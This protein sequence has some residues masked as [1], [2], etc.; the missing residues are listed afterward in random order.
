MATREGLLGE[1]V[2]EYY[3]MSLAMI[4]GSFFAGSTPLGGGSTAYP[5][6]VLLLDFTPIEGRDFAAMIQ[7]VGMGSATYLILLRRRHLLR[8][9]ILLINCFVGTMALA[10]A[11][12]VEIDSFALNCAFTTNL[13]CFSVIFFYFSEFLPWYT[14]KYHSKKNELD[15]EFTDHTGMSSVEKELADRFQEFD[16]YNEVAV[17]QHHD[18][19]RS[20]GVEPTSSVVHVDEV[21]LHV[22]IAASSEVGD[23]D[24]DLAQLAEENE[25]F[26]T[27]GSSVGSRSADSVAGEAPDEERVLQFALDAGGGAASTAPQTTST[28]RVVSFA[29]GTSSGSLDA[30]A[31]S[32]QESQ[33][34]DNASTSLSKSTGGRSRSSRNRLRRRARERVSERLV[35]EGV[36]SLDLDRSEQK[37]KTLEAEDAAARERERKE[38][39][40]ERKQLL[41]LATSSAGAASANSAKDP[42]KVGRKNSGAVETSKAGSGGA[43]ASCATTSAEGAGATRRGEDDIGQTAVATGSATDLGDEETRTSGMVEIVQE[44]LPSP[45]NRPADQTRAQVEMGDKSAPE[46]K[47]LLMMLFAI[48]GGILS[49]HIGGGAMVVGVFMA[50]VFVWNPLSSESEQLDITTITLNSVVSQAV[51]SWLVSF[52]ILASGGPTLRVWRCWASTVPIVVFGAPTGAILL[53]PKRIKYFR[54]LFI[55]LTVVQ[56]VCFA[57]LKIQS[58]LTA[59]ASILGTIGCIVVGLSLYHQTV[60]RPLLQVTGK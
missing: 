19:Q 41:G 28:R 38:R 58:D 30:G 21:G 47:Y 4:P 20:K 33:A 23:N 34:V 35:K 42:A 9:D 46:I 15:S 29:R 48:F 24:N 45:T 37:L 59:W 1:T 17:D 55:F 2:P 52:L 57:S 25:N 16:E 14:V 27:G 60:V 51:S 8:Q 12:N 11:F 18:E 13:L 26:S 10:I 53:N 31:S 6:G 56:F 32:Q 7:S 22:G 44:E 43:T 36:F 5:V 49:A 3:P 40:R 39:E 50:C 54:R